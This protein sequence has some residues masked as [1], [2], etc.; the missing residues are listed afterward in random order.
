MSSSAKLKGQARG[1]CT[2]NTR[3]LSSRAV[4]TGEFEDCLQWDLRH[5]EERLARQLLVFGQS[6]IV[7]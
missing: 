2:K 5:S 7:S 3:L 1:P 4:M 6:G